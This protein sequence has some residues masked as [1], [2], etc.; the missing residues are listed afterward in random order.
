MTTEMTG[1]VQATINNLD[2]P[3]EDL[4]IN[5]MYTIADRFFIAQFE[6]SRFS[7]SH[8]DGEAKA[9]LAA[10]KGG[11]DLST[12]N[13]SKQKLAKSVV[14]EISKFYSRGRDL[15]RVPSSRADGTVKYQPMRFAV[16]SWSKGQVL[17]PVDRYDDMMVA[18]HDIEG[19]LQK[20]LKA[21]KPKWDQLVADTKEEMKDLF[22]PN[23][24][25][26]YA[27]FASCWG[28]K[29]TVTTLPKLDPRIT[30]DAAQAADMREQVAR[31]TTSVVVEKLSAG[32]KNAA[33]NLLTSLEY[34][35]AVLADDRDAVQKL[36]D[37]NGLQ[38]KSTSKRAV[39][40]QESLFENLK[41]QLSTCRA[42]AAA[43]EDKG[44][45]E[46][47]DKVEATLG[48]IQAKHLRD[49]PDARR[50]TAAA[51]R[52]LVGQ[53][54]RQVANTTAEVQAVTNEL[55]AFA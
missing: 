32:W 52:L 43:T 15:V 35:T 34:V 29:I 9:E 53:A 21:I 2:I 45:H 18:F 11:A 1:S 30:L 47:T 3:I 24:I 14:A 22:D 37:P 10:A 44:L 12:F 40:V 46:L 33:E 36:N 49:N 5:R 38:P 39:A 8:S 55:G 4:Q 28:M 27:E 48:N 13:V 23:A 6:A 54:V 41:N 26:T 7:N 31:K 51:S 16:A 50:R 42:L 20:K 25:P 17:V 19:E